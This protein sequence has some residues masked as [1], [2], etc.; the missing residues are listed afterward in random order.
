M[1]KGIMLAGCISL[2]IINSWGAEVD[3]SDMGPRPARSVTFS[4]AAQEQE[5]KEG[6]HHKRQPGYSSES[7]S[8]GE[9]DA[10]GD[11]FEGDAVKGPREVSFPHFIE[12]T[13]SSLPQTIVLTSRSLPAATRREDVASSFISSSPHTYRLDLAA[14]LKLQVPV[15]TE[16]EKS[17]R[18]PRTKSLAREGTSNP[19]KD[20]VRHHSAPARDDSDESMFHMDM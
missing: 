14:R 20:K 19:A 17:S 12:N 8:S 4:V 7:E 1:M 11:V 18:K 13:E 6:K 9:E 2:M 3:D 15:S 16:G 5:L 10:E